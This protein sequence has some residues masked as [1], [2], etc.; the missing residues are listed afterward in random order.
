MKFSMILLQGISGDSAP[1]PILYLT[2]TLNSS[3]HQS[4]A[5]TQASGIIK[6]VSLPCLSHN[7]LNL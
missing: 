1:S 5:L 3:L 7:P 4:F 6:K 2:L